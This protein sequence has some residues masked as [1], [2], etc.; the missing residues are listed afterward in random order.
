[1][2]VGRAA[3]AGAAAGR[4][5]ARA[6]SGCPSRGR[7]REPP[8]DHRADVRRL[9]GGMCV[10]ADQLQTACTGDAADPRRRRCRTGF[11]L[12]EDRRRTHGRHRCSDRRHRRRGIRNEARCRAG[13]CAVLRPGLLGVAV[14]HQRNHRPVQGRDAVAPQPDG[15]DGRAP[16]GFRFA[17]RGLQP[18]ARRTD[19]ARLRSLHPALR[20]ARSPPGD[21]RIGRL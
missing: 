21:T 8:G 15:D 5:T 16:G 9:G 4:I 3:G 18:G 2:Y 10:P 6:G 7:Q 13:Q 17:R 19:V 14:L 20:A 1:M 12:A 11:R